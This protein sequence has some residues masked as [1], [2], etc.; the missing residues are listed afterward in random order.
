MKAAWGPV[1][2]CSQSGRTSTHTPDRVHDHDDDGGLGDGD[3]HCFHLHWILFLLPLLLLC[4]LLLELLALDPFAPLVKKCSFSRNL[5]PF[6]RNL[7]PFSA[8]AKMIGTF[9]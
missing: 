9:F 2:E 1:C 5:D 3:D 7:D 6:L 8:L 4:L